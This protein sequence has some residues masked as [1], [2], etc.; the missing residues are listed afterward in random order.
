MKIKVASYNIFHCEDYRKEK[1]DFDAFAE[2]IKSLD[3]DVIGLNEVHGEGEEEDYTEQAKILGELTGYNYFFAKAADIDGNNPF[4]NAVLTRLP[5]KEFSVIPIPDPEIPADN[6]GWYETRC[7]LKMVTATEPEVTFLITH[8]G[9]HK[10]EVENAVKTFCESFT[11]KKCVFMGDLNITPDNPLLDEIKKRMNDS[12]VECENEKLTFVAHDPYK[13][14][15]YIF[16]SR[17]IKPLKFDV[18]EIILSDHRP[19]TA[20]L[21]I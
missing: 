15:D 10:D 19:V 12:A 4:G 9:L 16:V 2:T 21:E 20:E 3:V 7:I 8:F 5:V 17:D 18:P 6:D 14:I 13:R 11:D 1:I